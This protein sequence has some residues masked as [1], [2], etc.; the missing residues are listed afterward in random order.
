METKPTSIRT[1]LLN[2]F[3]TMEVPFHLRSWQWTRLALLLVIDG[4]CVFLA[5]YLA[6]AARLDSLAINES[7]P[8]VLS[9]SP[10]VVAIHLSIFLVL[11][12][13]RPVWRYA[14]LH[15]VT[16]VIR[17][18]AL[19]SLVS[20][21]VI[22]THTYSPPLPR[23]IPYISFLLQVMFIL[24]T[25]FAWKNL[26]SFKQ[27]AGSTWKEPCLIYGAG[28]AGEMLA[29]QLLESP[30]AAFKPIGFVDD[31]PNLR[32]RFIQNIP[33]YGGRNWLRQLSS[34]YSVKKVIIAIHSVP[35]EV[36]RSLVT[37]CQENGLTPLIMPE[38]TASFSEDV[39]TPRAVDISDLLKRS[40]RSIDTRA[41]DQHFKD[42]CVLVTGAGGS[43]GSEICRQILRTEPSKLL[44]LDSSEHNLYQIDRELNASFPTLRDAIVPILGSVSNPVFVES[45][46]SQ[47]RPSCVLHAAA[48]KHVPLVEANPT[49]AVS[50]NVGGTKILSELSAKYGVGSFLLISSDKAVNPIGVMGAT[51]RICELQVHLMHRERGNATKFSAVRFGNVLGSSGS[52]IPLFLEQIRNGGP[53]T[54]THP[55]MKRYFMLISEAVS[56]VLQSAAIASG[57][58]IFVL[59]MGEPVKIYEM[60]KHL[61]R[62]AGKEPDKDVKIEFTGLRPGE[63]LFEELLYDGAES[64]SVRDDIYVAKAL[65]I[66]TEEIR[67]AIDSLLAEAEVGNDV[68]TKKIINQ[69]LNWRSSDSIARAQE[70]TYHRDAET[71]PSL[72]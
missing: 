48:Y 63:K 32:K 19:G 71:R 51:K 41:I 31:D 67:T 61:I 35:G 6:Y 25:R 53:V 69:I 62:L 42:K 15:N 70:L 20:W 46:I 24:S 13:Y 47:Y 26:I 65:D 18:V 58:E 45:V 55:E 16:M 22:S 3:I 12:M 28:R 8:T 52:V 34:T 5:Y 54:V 60:A 37:T 59:N 11:G 64:Y 56:L 68:E 7:L 29:R 66:S 40:P 36:I 49:Q 4:C 33:V 23:S 9:T 30:K 39:I 10:I 38:I 44:L 21:L 50:N 1:R 14:N 57:G 72:H 43:I 17:T 27:R 2:K